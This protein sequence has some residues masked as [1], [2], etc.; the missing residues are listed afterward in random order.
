MRQT[1]STG[2]EE[3]SRRRTNESPPAPHR[4][5]RGNLLHC[6]ASTP[7]MERSMPALRVA[8]A[9]LALAFRLPFLSVGAAAAQVMP[10]VGYPGDIRGTLAIPP[11]RI[12][13]PSRGK[14]SPTALPRAQPMPNFRGKLKRWTEDHHAGAGRRPYSGFPPHGLYQVLQGRQRN[15]G[16]EIQSGRP[17][18]DR[19]AGG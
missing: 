13:I 9:G 2:S 3:N 17:A 6:G 16:P 18:L 19:R 4:S 11:G 15:E 10:P 1:G 7:L 14:R 8:S 5:I 12:P